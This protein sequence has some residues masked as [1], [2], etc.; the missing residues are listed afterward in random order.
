VVEDPT[1]MGLF[2]VQPE[3]YRLVLARAIEEEIRANEAEK[4][5]G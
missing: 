2:D 3:P 4:A 1:G 5:A